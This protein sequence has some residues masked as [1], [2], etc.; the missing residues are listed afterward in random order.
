MKKINLELEDR[1]YSI[2]IGVS[3]FDNIL[4]YIKKLKINYNIFVV[5]DKNVEKFHSQKIK[6][7]FKGAE[8]EVHFHYMRSDETKKT[9]VE[10][11]R[12][13]SE[14]LQCHF[15]RDTLMVA[16]GGGL[17]GDI[18]GFAASSFMRGIPLIIVPTTLLACLDSSIGGKNGINFEN[19]KNIIGTFY[20]PKIV[21]TDPEF[22]TS[23]PKKEM[24]SG[25]GELIKYT[26]LADYNLFIKVNNYFN[27][28]INKDIEI[29]E[30]VIIKGASLKCSIIEQDEKEEG[31][32]KILNL[33]H[34]FGHSIESNLKFKITHGE[35]VVAGII[36]SLLLAEKLDIIMTA[37]KRFVLKI[38]YKNK[39]A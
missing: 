39:T 15:G 18:A 17:L 4:D 22:L 7:A 13:Y 16:I 27:D 33:G 31:I 1:S 35:S 9:M 12:I 20:Q 19:K 28:I 5:V 32:R 29:L 3:I 36:A 2:N 8:K 10:V 11:N 34:T 14:L 6:K 37:K 26:M 23:L 24:I 21:I 25:M 38:A 30:E